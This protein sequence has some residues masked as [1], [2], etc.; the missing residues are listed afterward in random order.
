MGYPAFRASQLS[1]H[2]FER[3]EAA[4][5]GDDYLPVGTSARIWWPRPRPRCCGGL[6]GS[7]VRTRE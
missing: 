3:F 7:R 4:P 2:Y 5:R 1:K 6:C